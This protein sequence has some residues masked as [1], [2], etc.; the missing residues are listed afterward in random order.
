MRAPRDRLRRRWHLTRKRGERLAH[1]HNTNRQDNVPEIGKKIASHTHRDGV[2]ERFPDPA[3][4][5]SG[6]VDLALIDCSDQ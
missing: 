2:A 1:I 4:P 3:V 5:K 6:A